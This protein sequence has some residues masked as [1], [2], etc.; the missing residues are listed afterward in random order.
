MD[1][2]FRLQIGLDNE[3]KARGY[4]VSLEDYDEKNVKR[5][6]TKQGEN[7]VVDIFAELLSE[8]KVM[9]ISILPSSEENTNYIGNI[10]IDSV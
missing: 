7:C 5:Y 6:C 3:N 4:L 1:N 8:E 9:K 2:R 10:V